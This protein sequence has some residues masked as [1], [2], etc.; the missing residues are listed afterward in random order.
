MLSVQEDTLTERDVLLTVEE[1]QDTNCDINNLSKSYS[2]SETCLKTPIGQAHYEANVER[3]HDTLT[4]ENTLR[5]RRVA[6]L[7]PGKKYHLFISCSTEDIT[8]VNKIC[9]ELE[10]RFFFKCMQHDRDFVIG[11]PLDDNI[12]SEMAKSVKVLILMSPAYITS[13][14]CMS[15]ADEAVRLSYSERE[16]LKIIP[17]LLRPPDEG[18]KLPPFLNRYRYIDSQKEKDITAKIFEAYYHSDAVDYIK[19]QGEQELT[20]DEIKNQNGAKLLTKTFIQQ[21]PYFEKGYVFE[22]EQLTLNEREYLKNLHE[23]C[24]D[25]FEAAVSLVT[26]HRLMKYYKIFTMAIFTHAA[27]FFFSA[28]FVS[29]VS[30]LYMTSV[31]IVRNFESFPSFGEVLSISLFGGCCFY[32]VFVVGILFYRR[33]MTVHIR[34]ELWKSV[35]KK[36]FRETKC[37]VDYNDTSVREPAIFIFR[38]DTT[39]CQEYLNVLI[40]QKYFYLDEDAIKTMAEEQIDEKLSELQRLGVL[41]EW[42]RLPVYDYNR[43]HTWLRKQ[44]LCQMLEMSLI[45]REVITV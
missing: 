39:P 15:E 43:H 42:F 11:K 23:K 10:S 19:I 7:P 3:G 41:A 45:Q 33:G 12:Q 5:Q 2:G 40:E 37:L 30:T 32:I 1:S 31:L 22:T 21:R 38:Y 4:P 35:N 8:E 14:W 13:R 9:K 34:K 18:L 36:Y 6:K 28:T 24:V 25:Q 29:S 44:C 27:A 17:V 26:N 20:E 16:K